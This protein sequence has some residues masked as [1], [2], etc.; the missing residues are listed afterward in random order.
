[1]AQNQLSICYLTK[2]SNAITEV[3]ATLKNVYQ[4]IIA[5]CAA[6]IEEISKTHAPDIILADKE[7]AGQK[8]PA[9]VLFVVSPKDAVEFIKTGCDFVTTAEVKTISLVRAVKNAIEKNRLARELSE[10]SIKDDMTGLY[11]QRFLIETLSREVQKANRYHYPLTLLYIGLDGMRRINTHFGPKAGDRLITDFGLIVGNSVRCVDAVGRFFGDE[12]LAILPETNERNSLKVCDRISRAMKNFAFANAEP[13]L[14]VSASI[15]IAS[16][17]A[18]TRT[19]Q[20]LLD[21]SRLAL[22]GAKKRGSGSVCTFEEAKLINEPSRKNEEL[23]TQ[24]KNTIF[25]LSENSKKHHQIEILKI[26]STNPAY[27]K[28]LTHAE[29]VALYSEKIGEELGLDKDDLVSLKTS[30]ILHDIGKI[31]IDDRIIFKNGPLSG[32]EY[33]IVRQ[34]PV[35]AAQMLSESLFLKKEINAILHHHENFDGTGYPDHMQASS[36]PLQSR[37]IALAEGW[38]TMITSQPY[39]DALALDQALLEIRNNAGKQFDPE[40]VEAFVNLIEN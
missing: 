14:E 20:E 39:R 32:T 8:F 18:E 2:K 1:M 3:A 29:H 36:I 25:N 12:F 22:A 16:L 19:M 10:A 31:A 35:L 21:A 30:A 17:S 37:I 4:K 40:V 9:P 24:I 27:Q 23:I 15:G 34:H 11:N 38:D 28:M 6:S 7:F 26:F 33:A 13:N 5:S